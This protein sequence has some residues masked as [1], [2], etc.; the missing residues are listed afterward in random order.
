MNTPFTVLNKFNKCISVLKTR[1]SV[2]TLFV[3]KNV[4]AKY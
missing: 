1:K 2:K 3:T 4:I